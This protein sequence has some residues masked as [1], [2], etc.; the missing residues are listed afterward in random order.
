MKSC[1]T[2]A[3]LRPAELLCQPTGKVKTIWQ[4]ALKTS[5][6]RFVVHTWDWWQAELCDA[7]MQ[8][9]GEQCQSK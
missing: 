1:Q 2:C 9:G 6:S 5:R 3:H 8:A 7:Y 4:S